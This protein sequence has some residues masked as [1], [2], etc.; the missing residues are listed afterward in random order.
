[1][2][3]G[4]GGGGFFHEDEVLGKAYDQRLMRW[5][6]SWLRPY[7]SRVVLALAIILLL[8]VAEI[9]P[10][11]I[12]KFIIDQSITPAV[13]GQIPPEL[14]LARLLPLG[15]LYL[16]VL[17]ASSGLRYTQTILTT[18][19]GQRAMFDLRVALF[20]HLQYLSLSFFDRNPVGR[21]MTRITND[22]DALTEMVT[23]G[24]V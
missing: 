4:H 14:G 18:S 11:I 20:R 13:G 23:Q 6:L 2:A 8:S 24:V 5:L 3:H 1:M 9:T 19:I 21:L 15:L 12:A 7:R 16:I 22:V 10:P 17:L